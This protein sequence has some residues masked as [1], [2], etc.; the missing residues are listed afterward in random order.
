MSYT[1]RSNKP[2]EYANKSNHSHIIKD[3]DINDFLNQCV[4]PERNIDENILKSESLFEIE[5]PKK[6]PIKFVIAID[7]GY[8][9]V[10]VQKNYPSSTIAFFQFGAFI[11]NI[12]DWK[13]LDDQ[14]FI[15]PEEMAVFNDLQRIKLV[16]PTKLIIL[17]DEESFT[18]SFRKNLYNFFR[19]D[20]GGLALMD[21]LYW[22]I[23]E[24]YNGKGQNAQNYVIQNPN[25]KGVQ[26]E[27]VSLKKSE[28]K[29]D[30]TFNIDG[31][32]V[33]L[34][35]IFRFHE[36][37]DDE[38]GAEG[39]LGNLATL[40]EQIILVAYIKQIMQKKPLALKEILFIKDGS[41]AF[42]DV[43]A[44]LHQPMR[45]LM[46]YLF[47]NHSLNLVGLEKSG[48]FTDHALS[49]SHE[50]VSNG[51]MNS[52]LPRNKFLLVSNDYIYKYI[53][54]GD[55]QKSIYGRTTHYSGKV[56]FKS[57]SGDTFVACIPLDA[58][59]PSEYETVVR[60]PVKSN[61]INIDTI[62]YNLSQLKCEM[63]DNAIVPITLA[64][65]LVSLADHPSK[66]ILEKFA[67]DSI[68]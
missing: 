19:K 61:F 66:S 50:S 49:I 5:V 27:S 28:M 46:K 47:Q 68:K 54:P 3:R 63:Y 42:Y 6:N 56:I 38:L 23:F 12:E 65:K 58:V 21:T 44:R 7:G 43:T 64:N 51:K 16:V 45:K 67:K 4:L 35:D 33:Y 11:L 36:K 32:T 17:K 10:E 22:L 34:T 57:L 2:N 30:Y 26:P 14:P 8:S 53:T 13:S 55:S 31:E 1:S 62:L 29:S 37:I 25:N 24:G 18:K 20:T 39:I 59:E 9:L 48:P 52:I 40:I 15:S 60:N 41:L